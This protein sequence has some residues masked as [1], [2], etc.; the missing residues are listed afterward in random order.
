MNRE[1]LH[2]HF[3]QQFIDALDGWTEADPKCSMAAGMLLILS[4]LRVK[5]GPTMAFQIAVMHSALREV[6]QERGYEVAANTL[7]GGQCP[8]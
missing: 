3:K 7:G 4:A 1:E 8:K 6:G 5:D 2:A